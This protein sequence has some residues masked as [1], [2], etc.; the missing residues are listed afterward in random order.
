MYTNNDAE[1]WLANIFM[2]TSTLK[3]LQRSTNQ[4]LTIIL[5]TQLQTTCVD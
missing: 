1:S 5:P 2:N 3:Q 4:V